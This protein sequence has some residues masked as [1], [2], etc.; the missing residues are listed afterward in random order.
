MKIKTDDT[1]I[2]DALDEL[3]L[4]TDTALA[5]KEVIQVYNAAM[6]ANIKT[7]PLSIVINP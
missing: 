6:E 4:R 3:V 5:V 2:K 1:Q 7:P